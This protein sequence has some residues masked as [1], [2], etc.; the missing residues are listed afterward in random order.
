M[1]ST[2][3][4][5]SSIPGSATQQ[6]SAAMCL[7]FFF[8]YSLVSTGCSATS[9]NN[10]VRCLS[11]SVRALSSSTFDDDSITLR[12]SQSTFGN[13]TALCNSRSG[14]MGGCLFRLI[15]RFVS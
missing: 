14:R 8:M 5:I 6:V 11:Y 15:T 3:L 7:A 10:P 9:A 13:Y 2:E 1:I 12:D 4:V